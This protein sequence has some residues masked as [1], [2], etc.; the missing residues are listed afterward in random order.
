MGFSLGF[1]INLDGKISFFRF[2][3]IVKRS[4][5]VNWLFFVFFALRRCCVRIFCLI[6]TITEYFRVKDRNGG[7]V[8]L[9]DLFNVILSVI[10][11]L[12]SFVFRFLF[13]SVLSYRLLFLE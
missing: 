2:L 13:V 7:L 9:I 8:K 1:V 12:V 4:R 11:K 5:F 6:F 3:L 10:L